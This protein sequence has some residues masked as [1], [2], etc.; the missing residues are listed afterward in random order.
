MYYVIKELQTENSERKGVTIEAKN[1]TA[2]KRAASRR[3][4]YYGTYIRLETLDGMWLAVKF[5][6]GHWE[7]YGDGGE[8][9]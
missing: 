3:Q 1:L 6:D 8:A 5:P 4:A 9:E 2:A 7:N